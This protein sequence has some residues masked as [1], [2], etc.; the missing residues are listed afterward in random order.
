MM[1]HDTIRQAAI[2]VASLDATQA[3]GLL[4]R[5]DTS[6]ADR[7]RKAVANL[8]P[9]DLSG[10]Q[11]VIEEFLANYEADA[12]SPNTT[13]P[14]QKSEACELSRFSA[15]RDTY[16]SF[17]ETK[18]FDFQFLYQV[19]PPLVAN[20]LEKLHKQI[21]AVI[22]A[23]MPADLSGVVLSYL[24]SQH[25]SEILARISSS[26]DCE[27]A[28][29]QTVSR[30][31]KDCLMDIEEAQSPLPPQLAAQAIEK[32]AQDNFLNRTLTDIES[33]GTELSHLEHLHSRKR[34]VGPIDACSRSLHQET[35][36]SRHEILRFED[37][38]LLNDNSLAKLFHQ[39]DHNTLLL[40]LAGTSMEVIQRII[41]PL[42]EQQAL[43]FTTK[44]EQVSGVSLLQI[45]N[46]QQLIAAQATRMAQE[47][48]IQFIEQKP[49][50][51]AA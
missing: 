16:T 27:F 25:Q 39:I 26:K 20:F 49:F 43:R 5:L 50:H 3:E 48:L 1:D 7:I 24:S 47:S 37:I 12:Q 15:G 34:Q 11:S 36:A 6:E 42:S 33:N 13:P 35:Q 41:S 51:A 28:Q 10:S 45:E 23:R 22:L 4:R 17:N 30:L 18:L 31:L 9:E 2:L 46:A 38:V 32:A 8:S 29:L 44:L 19:S 21:A 40:A 14:V